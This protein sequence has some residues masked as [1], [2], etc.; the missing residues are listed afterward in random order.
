[1]LFYQKLG[2]LLEDFQNMLKT[3]DNG[4]FRIVYDGSDYFEVI[5]DYGSSPFGHDST[6]GK[7]KEMKKISLQEVQ[8]KYP[9][10]YLL[11]QMHE[12]LLERKSD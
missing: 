3:H 1:M 10:Q 7:V 8:E 6:Y 11:I 2:F 5:R 12:L 9:R 4:M